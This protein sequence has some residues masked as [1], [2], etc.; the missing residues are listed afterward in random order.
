MK[1]RFDMSESLVKPVFEKLP[2]GA[3]LVKSGGSHEIHGDFIEEDVR[4]MLQEISPKIRIEE[5]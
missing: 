4:R 5:I 3:I 1:V 2:R